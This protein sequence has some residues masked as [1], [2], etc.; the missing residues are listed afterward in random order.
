MNSKAIQIFYIDDDQDDLDFFQEATNDIGES[1]QLFKLA[2][3]MI[4]TL[5][6]LPS[7]PTMLFLDLNMPIKSGFDIIKELR[8]S[9]AFRNLPLIVYSTAESTETVTRCRQLGASMYIVKP[10]SIAY[11]RK[12]IKYVVDVD[13]DSHSPDAKNFLYLAR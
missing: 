13:W 6:N 7:D 5:E 10:T 2:A 4:N 9:K 3:E 12:A 11:L 1:V 8:A